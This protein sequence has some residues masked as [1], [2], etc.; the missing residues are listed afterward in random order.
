VRQLDTVRNYRDPVSHAG[1]RK[2][3]ATPEIF[4][5]A[6]YVMCPFDDPLDYSEPFDVEDVPTD[7]IA[8]DPRYQGQIKLPG[9][10]RSQVTGINEIKR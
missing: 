10:E 9:G 4:V 7:V 8:S 6:R 2:E 5:Y 1:K 3:Y